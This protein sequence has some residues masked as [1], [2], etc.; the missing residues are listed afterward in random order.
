MKSLLKSKTYKIYRASKLV[1]LG[2]MSNICQTF[3]TTEFHKFSVKYYSFE[4][5][6]GKSLIGCLSM[7]SIHWCISID[8]YWS[9]KAFIKLFNYRFLAL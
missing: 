5:L 4:E 7:Y 2:H 6:Q 3:E 8:C 1:K 9:K